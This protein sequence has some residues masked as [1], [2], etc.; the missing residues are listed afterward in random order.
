MAQIKK[1]GEQII[2]KLFS[3]LQNLMDESEVLR[4]NWSGIISKVDRS[5]G[6]MLTTYLLDL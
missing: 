4:P 1:T 6:F 3:G 5:C 2:K